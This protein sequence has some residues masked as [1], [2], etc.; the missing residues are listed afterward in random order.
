MNRLSCWALVTENKKHWSMLLHTWRELRILHVKELLWFCLSATEGENMGYDTGALFHNNPIPSRKK[1]TPFSKSFWTSSVKK[2]Q[3]NEFEV[4]CD[5][6]F[7]TWHWLCSKS[8]LKASCML[9]LYF[10]HFVQC[11]EC[12]DEYVQPVTWHDFLI[13]KRKWCPSANHWCQVNVRFLM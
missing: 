10:R 6:I 3:V 5:L 12:G 1:I 7:S 11:G 8:S 9:V 2:W 13:P 4:P